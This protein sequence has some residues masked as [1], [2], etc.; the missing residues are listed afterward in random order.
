MTMKL[1]NLLDYS[2]L[3]S[4]DDIDRA[5]KF[6]QDYMDR[7]NA[8]IVRKQEELIKNVLQALLNREPTPEDAKRLSIVYDAKKPD[9][10]IMYFDDKPIGKYIVESTYDIQNYRAKM[11]CRFEPF[12]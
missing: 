8:E 4:N 7:V 2:A 5:L 12:K 10:R 1:T 6:H 9:D 11:I 3:Y